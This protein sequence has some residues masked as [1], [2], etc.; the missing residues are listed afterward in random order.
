M[1]EFIL[2]TLSPSP[3][4]TI[5]LTV[6]GAFFLAG[7]IKGFLGIG[8]PPAV[9]AIL[10]L[11]MDITVAISL[12]T[13]PIIFTNLFQYMRCENRVAIAKKY[14]LLGISIMISIFLTSFFIMSF[15]KAVLMV[16]I[17]FA[18]ITFSLTQM[19]G[20]KISLGH[21]PMWHTSVGLFS[22]ILGGLSSIWSPPIAMYLLAHNVSKSEFIGATGFLFLAGSIPLAIG[23]T[24][25]GVLTIN[26]VLHSLMGLIVVLAGFRIGESLRKYAKQELFSRIF[27]WA[28]LIMG[29]R[30]IFVAFY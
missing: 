20:T 17:G 25:A 16:S 3:D 5:T 27:L 6:L 15:P 26:T 24:F 10:T 9:M 30:L 19:F 21:G 13:L 7:I 12:L 1:I 8:L 14:W 22:G 23:L 18:M 28:F 11:V 4:V 2:N 29:L